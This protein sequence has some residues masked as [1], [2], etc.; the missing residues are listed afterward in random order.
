LVFI[1]RHIRILILCFFVVFFFGCKRN[2]EFYSEFVVNQQNT[3]LPI[4]LKNKKLTVLFEESPTSY[5]L[6][7]NVVMGFEYEMLKQ[8]ASDLGVSLEVKLLKNRDN[9]IDLLKGGEVNILACSYTITKERRRQIDFSYPYL[10]TPQVL[11]QRLP[12]DSTPEYIKDPIQLINKNVTVWANSSYYQRLLHIQ[13]ELGDSIFIH[14]VNGNHSPDS[15]MRSVSN[16]VIDYTVVDNHIAVAN[17]YIFK[18]LDHHLRLSLKQQIA[19]GLKKDNPLLKFRLNKWLRNF[20]K[21]AHFTFLK[22]K[23][24]NGKE[25]S[26]LTYADYM[27]LGGSKLSAYDKMFK[28][29]AKKYNMD[30]QLIAAIVRQESNFKA[31]V[32]GRGG[33]FG[34]MQ[35]MPKTGAKYGITPESAPSSQIAAGMKKIHKDFMVWKKVKDKNQRI[36]FAIATYNSGVSHI[37][38]AQRLAIKYGL[39]PFVWDE[40]VELMLRNLSKKEYYKDEVVKGGFAKGNFTANYVDQVFA[41]YLKYQSVFD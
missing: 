18:N 19:F 34:L 28:E 22:R 15:L 10:R 32:V 37:L 11:I 2:K 40:N 41:R 1:N 20:K 35:F 12:N 39:N 29:E 25:L 3:D 7:K 17:N 31:Y 5:I 16:K 23:Y 9:A 27:D 6:Y 13:H 24:F 8:F 30:W 33:S 21:S 26:R 4:I 38:D 36:K 14:A